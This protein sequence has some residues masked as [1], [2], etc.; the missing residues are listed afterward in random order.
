MTGTR[1]PLEVQPSIPPRLARLSELAN[2]LLYSWDRQV[3]GLFFRLDR[4]LWE[5]CG[6][7]PKVFL[8]RVAQ[9]KLDAAV[10]DRIFMEDYNRALSV[11]DVYLES[12]M[13]AEIAEDVDPENDLVAYFCA[14]F[15]FHESVPL[16]SGGLGILAGDHCKAASD[17]VLPFIAVGL[18]YRRGYFTQTV[19]GQGNQVAHYM[20]THFEDIPVTP[21]VDEHEKE[22]HVSVPMDGHDVV[23]KVWQAQAGHIILYLLDADLPENSDEDRR[24]TYQLYGGDSTTRIQQEIALGIGGVRALRALGHRPTVWHINEG[25][26]AFQI[27]ERARERV[28]QGMDFYSAMELI[29]AGTVYTTHTP[30]PAGHDI[31]DPALFTRFFSDYAHELKVSLED[32]MKL[33]HSPSNH[34]GFNMTALAMRGSRFQN[35]VSRIHGG[36]A[37]NMEG[38][39]RFDRTWRN[40]LL[41]ED[42]WQRIDTIPDQNYWSVRQTL[43]AELMDGVRERATKQLRRN[44]CSDVQIDRM[45]RHLSSSETD[46]LTLGFARRFATYKRALL[47]FSDPLRL[48]RIVNDPNRPVLIMFAGKAHPSDVPGQEL[49][50]TIHEYSRRP[51]F[52][53]KIILLEN[54]D[55]AL[56]RK[57]VSGVDVWLNTPEYPLEAS[58]TSGQKAGINGIVNL[59]VLDGWWGEGYNGENGWAITPHGQQYDSAFRD[60]EEA[61]TLLDIL[62]HE[63]VPLYYKR[64]GHG[65]S[66]GWVATSKASMKSV[67]PHFNAQRMVMDY[68]RKFYGPAIRQRRMLIA[69][70]ARPARELAQWKSRVFAAWSGVGLRRIDDTRTEILAGESLV[71]QVA[72]RLNGLQADDVL[73]ECL[74]GTADSASDFSFDNRYFFDAVREL[75][76]GETLFELKLSP[77]LAGLQFYKVRMYPWH[78][79]LSHPF[80]MGFMIWL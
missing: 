36:V 4:E 37:S 16:Y 75:E 22:L 50:R 5:A 30:V 61:L 12:P 38:Y 77:E 66:E 28:A 52:E 15:G 68:V 19:D 42:Y 26:A 3:R 10:D 40:E 57:L 23:F 2:D 47:L 53:G 74:V 76:N 24:I 49:I 43:K 1:F 64:N 65:Y 14:E 8:R 45:V 59:S 71:I 27:L 6:H 34:G 20:M 51:E 46:I 11:Y 7:N 39:M 32:L 70:D 17:L 48:A 79:L 13:R 25:H 54:Y 58:G 67:M 18:L 73:L 56:A 31:F 33:G 63:V 78:E 60:R 41:D 80:E 72:A 29:A 44:G 35:G 62:E 69:D 9:D 21:A 55:L